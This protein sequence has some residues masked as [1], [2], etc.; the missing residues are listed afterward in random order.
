VTLGE[1]DG[2]DDGRHSLG[3]LA[4]V[5]MRF[6]EDRILLEKLDAEIA[7]SGRIS[8][9]AP[10]VYEGV[11]RSPPTGKVPFGG[12]R[13]SGRLSRNRPALFALSRAPL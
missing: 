8:R 3:Y 4:F 5:W 10:G 12:G 9:R 2:T 7:N 6:Q 1:V 11:R 13:S